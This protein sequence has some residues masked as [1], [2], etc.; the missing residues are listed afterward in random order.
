MIAVGYVGRD[1]VSHMATFADHIA[2]LKKRQGSA[3][4]NYADLSKAQDW[5]DELRFPAIIER[6]VAPGKIAFE[7][8]HGPIQAQP[9]E[10]LETLLSPRYRA[11]WN[12]HVDLAL[13]KN[14]HVTAI[15][16]V[17]TDLGP[18]LFS[19]IGQ[20][21]WYRQLFGS[22]A[23]PLFL[24]V[25]NDVRGRE[26]LVDVGRQLKALGIDLVLAGKEDLRSW[27][28]HPLPNLLRE[29]GIRLRVRA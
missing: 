22:A 18:Q 26:Q 2:A 13:L 19:G 14:D 16:E 17:K 4:G 5:R 8:Q 7:Y 27:N 12:T 10:L 20:L 21:Y 3:Q 28:D 29:K 24:V 1:L 9:Q 15:F 25:P 6:A 11:V 23:T